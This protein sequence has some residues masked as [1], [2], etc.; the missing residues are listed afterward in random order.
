[1]A[2]QHRGHDGLGDGALRERQLHG[3]QG[4]ELRQTQER[5]RTVIRLYGREEQHVEVALWCEDRA[6]AG[7][8]G[9]TELLARK[10]EHLIDVLEAVR[11][12][13]ERQVEQREEQRRD[14]LHR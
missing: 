6:V 12:A 7:L 3:P 11:V 8:E 5:E 9:L 2:T 4:V 1:M 14:V 10:A 13:V